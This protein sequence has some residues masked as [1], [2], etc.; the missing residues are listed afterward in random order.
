MMQAEAPYFDGPQSFEM[1]EL[2]RRIRH[3]RKRHGLTQEELGRL[4]GVNPSSVGRW[5]SGQA[6]PEGATWLLLRGLLDGSRNFRPLTRPE[7]R[8]LDE[9]VVRGGFA[10]RESFLSAC[11]L[12]LLKQRN[13]APAVPMAAAAFS[14]GGSSTG[15]RRK[16]EPDEIKTYRQR[17]GLTL[18]ALGERCGVSA[19]A[20]QQWEAGRR[21]SG[22]SLIL[23]R[24]LLD[25]SQPVTPLTSAEER[26]LDEIVLRGDFGTRERFLAMWLSKPRQAAP[27]SES[28][29]GKGV[30]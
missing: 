7:E 16:I 17:Q 5:E 3:F 2:G 24:E 20:V 19:S 25:E 10:T 14:R 29:A 26:L 13:I 4:C 21:I 11:L 22:S 1:E 28:L 23:L 12:D 27:A 6:V 9:A 8:L 18:K 30:A 15:N